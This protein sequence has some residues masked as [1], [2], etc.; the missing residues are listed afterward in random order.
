MG[1]SGQIDEVIRR[2]T[3]VAASTLTALIQGETGTGKE[4]VARAIHR[5]SLRRQGRFTAVDCGA[6]PETLI[7]SELFGHEKGA[8]T[9]AGERKEGHFQLA[10]G[11][12]LFLDEIANLPW[13]TQSRLLR[14]LQ[15][16]VVQPLGG[17]F[18]V[19]V[20]VRIIATSNVSLER[21]VRANR[22]RQDLYYRLNEFTITLPPLRQR[23]EDIP[24]LA[25]RFLVEA[26]LEL[27]RPIHGVSEEATRRLCRHNWPGN[28]R[29]LRSTIRQ[30]V[31]LSRDGAP[32]EDLLELPMAAFSDLPAGNTDSASAGHSLRA[33]A[34]AAAAA[35][36][37]EAIS[38]ALHAAK[39][40][41]SAVA[42]LLGVDYK[43]LHLKLK[44]YG[45]CARNFAA[46]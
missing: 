23:V 44:R 45:I 2:V 33:I 35:A 21:E 24:Y 32:L 16:R 17:R 36:E 38:E 22:F 4:L 46:L 25:N 37:R 7:E 10:Q 20:D 41:K 5:L 6:I 30:A 27:G 39:G 14:A 31:L 9:G 1:P 28:V 8:F 18:P 26:S 3:Q 29:E 15:E 11:G 34:A 40:N 12:T 19:P 43:T 13:T 42:R